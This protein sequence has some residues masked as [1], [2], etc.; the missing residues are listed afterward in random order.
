ML[1]TKTG[2]LLSKVVFRQRPVY[3]NFP[4]RGIDKFE[5]YRTVYVFSL[6]QTFF[7]KHVP[8]IKKLRNIF[9]FII[10]FET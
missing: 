7:T 2:T 6:K 8:K 10:F 3:P 1:K 9:F 5:P 4:T